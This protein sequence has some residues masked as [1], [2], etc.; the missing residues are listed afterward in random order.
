LALITFFLAFGGV[1]YLRFRN[2]KWKSI[3]VVQRA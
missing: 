2:G 3:A 1:F